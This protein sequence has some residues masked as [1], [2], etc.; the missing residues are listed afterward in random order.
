MTDSRGR[1]VP[2]CRADYG[3][4]LG[5]VHSIGNHA[6]QDRNIFQEALPAAFGKPAER[7]RAVVLE[8]LPDLDKA[9]LL[10]QLKLSAQVAVGQV[11][12]RF[13][14]VEEQAVG[15]GRQ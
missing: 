1:W 4:L 5:R 2:R 10:K 14:V 9:A 8:A 12:Q 13:K 3:G 11:T 15:V 7:L 6:F